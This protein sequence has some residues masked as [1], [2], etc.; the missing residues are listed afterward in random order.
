VIKSWAAKE[1]RKLFEGKASRIPTDLQKRALS[2]L[3]AIHAAPSL[4]T[5]GKVPGNEL[6]SLCGDRQ[7]QHSIRINVQYRVCFRWENGD[8]YEVEVIDY[9]G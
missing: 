7:G 5:L 9:H 3:Q 6:E 4:E 2:K 1:T 8:A